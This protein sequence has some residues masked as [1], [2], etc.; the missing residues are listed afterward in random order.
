MA[1]SLRSKFKR[2][3]RTLKRSSVFLPVEEARL[4]RL[5]VKQ[6]ECVSVS[7]EVMM[8]VDSTESTESTENIE[9]IE[10]NENTEN[11]KSTANP[12]QTVS[13]KPKKQKMKFYLSNRKYRRMLNRQKFK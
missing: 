10:S 7:G 13:K 12:D 5:A 4:N 11:T 2:K 8:A 9:T 3:Q 6:A 1:K